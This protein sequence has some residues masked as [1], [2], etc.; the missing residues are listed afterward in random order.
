MRQMTAAGGKNI[1]TK[2]NSHLLLG[3]YIILFIYMPKITVGEIRNELIKAYEANFPE[4][5][6]RAFV[7]NGNIYII[8][9]YFS[10]TCITLQVTHLLQLRGYFN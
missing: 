3:V 6:R 1:E 5:L 4:F 9:F 7:I 2:I 10:N 8:K